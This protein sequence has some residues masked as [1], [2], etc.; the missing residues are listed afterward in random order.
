MW[1]C[2]FFFKHNTRSVLFEGVED[3]KNATCGNT[4]TWRNPVGGMSLERSSV[5]GD[6]NQ[7]RFFLG[8]QNCLWK[9]CFWGS[10]MT[11]KLL[12]RDRRKVQL[13]TLCSPCCAGDIEERDC[14][15]QCQPAS[16]NARGEHNVTLRTATSDYVS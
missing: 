11:L 5:K 6:I 7:E 3:G 15:V 10:S 2:A 9:T 4:T 1:T 8:D 16:D 14:A 13:L 12:R